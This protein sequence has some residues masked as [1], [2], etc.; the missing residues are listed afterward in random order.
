[1][2]RASNVQT[3]HDHL[4]RRLF[5]R[6]AAVGALLR[7]FLP[8][9]FAT[10]VRWRT[11]RPWPA[12]TVDRRLRAHLPDG[13]QR[14]RRARRGFVWFVHEHKSGGAPRVALQVLR[15]EVQ[16]LDH[17]HRR[18]PCGR[19]PLVVPIVWSHG[20]RNRAA[21]DAGD[22]LESPP[23]ALR[24]LRRRWPFLLV[25]LS[26]WPEPAMLRARLPS[27]AR[28]VVLFLQYL[29]FR[30]RRAVV[31]ALHRWAGPLRAL[32]R[33]PA[34][35]E[36]LE[37]LSSYILFTTDLPA[38]ALERVL[39][40]V[41]GSRGATDMITTAERLLRQGRR[42]GLQKGLQK[43]MQK[44]LQKGLQEGHL[45]GC[46]GVL[47]T[48]LEGRFGKLGRRTKSRLRRAKLADLDRWAR[49]LLVA[50]TLEDVFAA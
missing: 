25:D 30:P 7:C 10:S 12:R 41:V 42:E 4:F 3:P 34:G 39:D 27:F 36:D 21:T 33:T 38:S 1:M 37:T 44:G 46:I 16:L 2:H 32:A 40:R 43:G 50:E 5:A 17:L 35:R 6:P 49:A 45:A 48:I 18:G 29:A 13:V 23:Q 31:A 28:L 24:R 47:L 26:R 22:L 11:L 20:K 14:A 8:R 15:Y 9:G 19:L